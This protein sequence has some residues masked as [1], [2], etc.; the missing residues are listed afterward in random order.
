M[1]G[2][3]WQPGESREGVPGP[4]RGP[5]QSPFPHTCEALSN[6]HLVSVA[7]PVLHLSIYMLPATCVCACMCVNLTVFWTCHSFI[8]TLH[9]CCTT[10]ALF[11]FGQCMVG[12]I[13]SLI[14]YFQLRWISKNRDETVQSP[15]YL[16]LSRC[17]L[18]G[19]FVGGKKCKKKQNKKNHTTEIK[20]GM[21]YRCQ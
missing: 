2:S 16:N 21:L 13:N 8:T 6:P 14:F 19:N 10:L 4:I 5:L 18:K 3:S 12:S 11:L 9:R 17:C 7:I 15:V 20:L 1:S